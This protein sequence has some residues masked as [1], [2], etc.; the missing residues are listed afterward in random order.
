METGENIHSP[1]SRQAELNLCSP[2]QHRFWYERPGHFTPD[3]LQ[4]LRQ[5]SLARVICDNA[6]AIEYVPRDVFVLE[7]VSSFFHC[8][9]LPAVDLSLWSDCEGKWVHVHVALYYR[10]SF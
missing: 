6:D 3:Q 9:D 7:S 10:P 5:S 4:Q 8:E 1:L 2:L